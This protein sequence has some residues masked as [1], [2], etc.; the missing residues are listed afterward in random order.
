MGNERSDKGKL[1]PKKVERK[2]KVKVKV[3]Q[4]RGTQDRQREVNDLGTKDDL[5]NT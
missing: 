2:A 1:L 5:K 4:K 3:K